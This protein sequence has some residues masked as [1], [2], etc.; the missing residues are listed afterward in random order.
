MLIRMLIIKDRHI[1][2]KRKMGG[3]KETMYECMNEQ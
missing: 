1:K 2:V 3:A